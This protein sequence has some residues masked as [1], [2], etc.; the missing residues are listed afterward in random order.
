MMVGWAVI[1]PPL[2]GTYRINV[3]LCDGLDRMI[4]RAPRQRPRIPSRKPLA[5]FGGDGR[6]ADSDSREP[7]ASR[8]RIA[9]VAAAVLAATFA[10]TQAVSQDDTPYL[11]LLDAYVRKDPAAAVTSLG[12]WPERRVKDAVR[13]LVIP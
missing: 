13:A 6:P 12:T 1:V 4:I 9:P 2:G 5:R 10:T 8:Y 3:R 7:R 11:T